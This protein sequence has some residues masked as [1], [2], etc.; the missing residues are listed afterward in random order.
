ML[1]PAEQDRRR[2]ALVLG[3]AEH[4]DR[5]GVGH[6][7]GVVVVRGAPHE[8]SG[9]DQEQDRGEHDGTER[10][11]DRVAADQA[12]RSRLPDRCARSADREPQSRQ[13][14]VARPDH[15]ASAPAAV[16]SA[17]TGASSASHTARM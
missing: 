14:T 2:R 1:Q 17:R 5:V 12:H 16:R 4:D 10:G 9:K 7:A 3:G 11:Q 13:V 6:V 8:G 15:S